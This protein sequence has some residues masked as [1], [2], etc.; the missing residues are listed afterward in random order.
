MNNLEKYK[1]YKIIIWGHTWN[2]SFRWIHHRFHRAFKY[3][4]FDV[5]W[6]ENKIENIPNKNDNNIIITENSQDL[7]LLQNYSNNWIIFDH[8]LTLEKYN[9]FNISSKNIIPFWVIRNNLAKFTQKTLWAMITEFDTPKMSIEDYYYYSRMPSIYWGSHLLPNEIEFKPYNYLSK[10]KDIV[11]IWSWWHNN[12]I[13][14]ETLRLWSILHW[15]NFKQLWKHLLLRPP[16]VKKT[17]IPE[18]EIENLSR[19]AYISPAIQWEQ[20]NDWYIPCRLFINMSLSILWVS[21]NPYVYNLFD[22]DEVIIDRDIF[23]MMEKAE[24]VIKDKKVD[25]YTKKAVRKVKE[26]HT[27]INRID[28]LFS[29]LN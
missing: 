3:L 22:D 29:Y 7:L 17:F 24:K 14:L 16:L 21:N 25:E 28:E 20:V 13:Q 6:L 19:N 4:E 15:K 26:K 9:Q 8:N 18:N 1:N 5:Q 12:F 27:Y 2:N 23:K 11:F 10:S